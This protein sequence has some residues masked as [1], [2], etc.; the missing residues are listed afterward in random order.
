MHE[1]LKRPLF[2]KKAMEVYQA[3]QGGK[4]PGYVYGAL[5]QGARAAGPF[6]ARQFARPTVQKGLLG[7][8]GAGIA[9]GVEETKRGIKGEES[10][11][12]AIPGLEGEPATISGGLATLIPGVGFAGKTL[13]RAFPT[14]TTAAGAAQAMT[15]K[16]PFSYPGTTAVLGIPLTLAEA[17]AR[18]A[19]NYETQ[20]RVPKADQEKVVN[21]EKQIF[22]LPENATI[23][24]AADLILNADISD[25]A[26]DKVLIEKLQLTPQAVASLK[27]KRTEVKIQPSEQGTKLASDKTIEQNIQAQMN[28]GVN[29]NNMSPEAQQELAVKT[30][31]QQQGATREIEKLMDEK[32]DDNNFKQQFSNLKNQIQ[33]V[34]GEDSMSN[35]VLLKMAAGLLTG[36]TTQRGVSGLLDVVGQAAGP[37]IDTAILLANQQKEFDKDLALALIKNRAEQTAGP[38]AA[39]GL[40]YYREENID[41]K[42][43]KIDPDFPIIG[44]VLRQDKD[45]GAALEIMSDPE[46]GEYFAPYKGAGT[47]F[48][49]NQRLKNRAEQQMRERETIIE[50]ANLVTSIDEKFLGP[51]PTAMKYVRAI[52]GTI[53]S[54]TNGKYANSEAYIN[55]TY[56]QILNNI[57]DPSQYEGMSDAMKTDR[58]KAND[59]LITQFKKE[60]DEILKMKLEALKKGDEE[61][62]A[63]ANLSFIENRMKYSQANSNK[64]EDRVNQYDVIS[65]ERDTK[66]YKLVSDPRQIK[67]NYEKIARDAN[68]NF[69][70]DAARYVANAGRINDVVGLYPTVP[71]VKEYVGKTQQK[72]TK[73]TQQPDVTKN[74]I[75]QFYGVK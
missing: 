4:V 18:D 70:K 7:L 72:S 33:S 46:K 30:V 1:S 17:K 50:M 9:A 3:K 13:T 14:S 32:K 49:P 10:I 34:T 41:P 69:G 73:Q 48:V 45:T 21:L 28:F 51:K 29:P 67:I 42:T 65:A 8:E 24:D 56:D 40:V 19:I 64:F 26:K 39:S 58:A 52:D 74:L 35:L 36:K 11:Y 20:T 37:A 15:T 68:Q 60:N 2:R 27:E 57:T 12:S 31:R 66:I 22:N 44:K 55:A 63:Q 62:V 54:F 59:K 71:W 38:K 75:E 6:I 47:P 25:A 43:G 53:N 5:I 61:R 23:R 16:F